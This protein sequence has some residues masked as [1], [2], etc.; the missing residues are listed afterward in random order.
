LLRSRIFGFEKKRTS[1]EF[2]G[3]LKRKSAAAV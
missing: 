3:M 1:E 2:R